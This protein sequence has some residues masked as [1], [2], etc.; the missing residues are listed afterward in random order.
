MPFSPKPLPGIEK[1]DEKSISV[2]SVVSPGQRRSRLRS[3][4]GI[5][6]PLRRRNY[7]LLVG[8]QLVSNIGDEFYLVALPWFLLNSGGGAQALG[9]VLAAYGIPR[10]GSLMLGGPLSDRLGPR[11]VMLLSDCVRLIVMSL[12]AFVVLFHPAVWLLCALAACNGAF[13]GMFTPAA[14]SITAALLP[15][16]EL[17]AGNALNAGARNG[18]GIVGSSVAGVVVSVFQPAVAFVVDAL[19][20]V[21]S[22][23]TLALMHGPQA[24]LVQH[25]QRETSSGPTMPG[26]TEQ[27]GPMTFW[28]LWRTSRFLRTMLTRVTFMNLG[29]G[30][31]FGVA[32]P[33]FAHDA[34]RSGASGYGFILTAFAVGAFLGAVW[35]GTLG[36]MP[37][38]YTKGLVFFIMQAAITMLIPFLSS[39]V[40]VSL[41]MFV[42]GVMNGLGNVTGT[43][44]MQQVLPRPLMGRI[45]GA[46]ALTNFGFY[47]LSVA[48]G[49]VVVALYGPLFLFLLDGA[50]IMVPCVYSIV[51]LREFWH[52]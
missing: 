42:A 13:T 34:L 43:T 31:T 33:V 35:A 5:L 7:R 52:V 51:F 1:Q 25:T 4:N 18:A 26:E 16:N 3:F 27:T 29:S 46:L 48:L 15:D 32:L 14:W 2:H 19:S 47:P 37:S 6:A 41:A 49:G 45:M 30:A 10:V 40:A 11:N 17:Q 23:V 38:R 12:F 28:Q 9:L 22:A 50:L 39:V 36:N 21:V 20:F 44:I 8:G 24:V